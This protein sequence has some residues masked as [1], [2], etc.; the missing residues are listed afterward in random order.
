MTPTKNLGISAKNFGKN[1]EKKFEA[2]RKKATP[3]ITRRGKKR[4]CRLF[5]RK[6]A[7]GIETKTV[8]Q[9]SRKK[10]EKSWE[11]KKE[12]KR[13]KILPLGKSHR[14][15][16]KEQMYGFLVT[17]GNKAGNCPVKRKSQK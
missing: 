13:F 12:K 17:Y 4:T 5:P 14:L 6:L 3:I 1:L 15:L 16:H 9:D 8:A 7:F 11:R 10:K 2:S